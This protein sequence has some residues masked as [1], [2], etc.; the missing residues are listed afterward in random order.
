M[1]SLLVYDISN[2]Y[3]LGTADGNADACEVKSASSR[4]ISQGLEESKL[5]SAP[6]GDDIGSVN[7]EALQMSVGQ[8]Q[9]MVEGEVEVMSRK[10][11]VHEDSSGTKKVEDDAEKIDQNSIHQGSVMENVNSLNVSPKE[12]SDRSVKQVQNIDD[13]NCVMDESAAMCLDASPC[14]EN[15]DENTDVAV[16]DTLDEVHSSNFEDSDGKPVQVR[17]TDPSNEVETSDLDVHEFVVIGILIC[18]PKYLCVKGKFNMTG[19]I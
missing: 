13:N 15:T 1:I 7:V 18:I 14:V 11:E 12:S 5:K 9:N 2:L 4:K 17:S 10:T 16:V 19:P 8:E 3:I 6:E